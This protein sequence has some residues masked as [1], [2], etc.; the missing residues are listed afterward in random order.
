MHVTS[1]CDSIESA[2]LHIILEDDSSDVFII[3]RRNGHAKKC[4][5]IWLAII[6]L[7][8]ITST[9][10]AKDFLE[11]NSIGVMV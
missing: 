7:H 1:C 8:V 4:V 10:G 11:D 2:S 5:A 3:R 9:G 6:K